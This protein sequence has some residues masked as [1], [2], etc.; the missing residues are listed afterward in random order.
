MVEGEW[1]VEIQDREEEAEELPKGDHHGYCETCTFC[2]QYKDCGDA[3]ILSDDV[4]Q[5]VDKHGGH[6]DVQD[7]N[8]NRGARHGDVPMCQDVRSQ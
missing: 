3:D 7:R 8:E 4:A 2:C 1:V 6:A 5:E